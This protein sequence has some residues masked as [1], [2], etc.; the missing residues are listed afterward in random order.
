MKHQSGMRAVFVLVTNGGILMA[1]K[2]ETSIREKMV[3]G[4]GDMSSAERPMDKLGIE[5]Y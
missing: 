4:R 2:G 1:R 5:E 3:V